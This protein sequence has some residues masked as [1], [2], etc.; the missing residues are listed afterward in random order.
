LGATVGSKRCMLNV[1]CCPHQAVICWLQQR[2][3]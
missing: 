2:R 3:A 1:S